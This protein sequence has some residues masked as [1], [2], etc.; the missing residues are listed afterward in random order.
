MLALERLLRALQ[1]IQ[2]IFQGYPS[3]ALF[4]Q[5]NT[6]LSAASTQGP[7]SPLCASVRKLDLANCF[8]VFIL[9]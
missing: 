9:G 6:P 2:W 8:A 5:N 4:R 7:Q 3:G 1:D